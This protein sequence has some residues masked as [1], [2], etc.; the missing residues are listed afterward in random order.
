MNFFITE[1]NPFSNCPI[2]INKNSI[3][4]FKYIF[5]ILIPIYFIVYPNGDY[6]S[7]MIGIVS[8]YYFFIVQLR[9]RITPFNDSTVEILNIVFEVT[10]YWISFSVF[11]QSVLSRG[12]EIDNLGVLYAVIGLVINVTVFYFYNLEKIQKFL[13]P[14]IFKVES[15]NTI[16]DFCYAII[17]LNK[18]A[19]DKSG[20]IQLHYALK[21]CYEYSIIE[22][23]ELDDCFLQSL[24]KS[25]FPF[26]KKK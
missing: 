25:N 24:C 13:S 7:I 19:D 3:K 16:I 5:K 20:L 21:R 4:A 15:E 12:E 9:L 17:H 22:E 8:A 23:I 14:N 1:M 10:L 6:S 2:A 18:R 26:K 11:I